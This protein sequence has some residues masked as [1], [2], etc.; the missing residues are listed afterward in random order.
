M[1]WEVGKRLS[2]SKILGQMATRFLTEKLYVYDNHTASE[3]K[4]QVYIIQLSLEEHPSSEPVDRFTPKGRN[5]IK[6]FRSR[7]DPTINDNKRECVLSLVDSL[8]NIR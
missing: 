8:Y 5:Q 4:V 3:N 7:A 1:A 6:G 2:T